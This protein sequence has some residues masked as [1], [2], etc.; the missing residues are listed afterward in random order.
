MNTAKD[1][2]E[3]SMEKLEE[4]VAELD[5]GDFTLEESLEKFETGLKLGKTCR[6]ILDKA[7][8]RVNKL[9]ENQDGAVEEVDAGDEFED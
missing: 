5:K 6:K 2:F 4:I 7:E 8:A 1:S 3:T 9:V